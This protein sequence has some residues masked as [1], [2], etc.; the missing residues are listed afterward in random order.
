MTTGV[1]EGPMQ[2]LV[3]YIDQTWIR[4]QIWPVV[5]WSI[6][7]QAIRTNNEVEGWHT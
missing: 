3:D 7:G 1:L 5:S 6:Y 4:S 2:R